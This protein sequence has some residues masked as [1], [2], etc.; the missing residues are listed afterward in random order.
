MEKKI[1]IKRIMDNC[2][3]SRLLSPHGNLV[4]RLIRFCSTCAVQPYLL[5]EL[6]Q[7]GDDTVTQA[8]VHGVC[9]KVG[10]AHHPHGLF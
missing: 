5:A 10:R 4:H 1:L 9:Y 3:N 8:T 2:T 7:V 6:L